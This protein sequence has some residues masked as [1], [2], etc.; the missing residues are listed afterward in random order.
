MSLMSKLIKNNETESESSL[1]SVVLSKAEA[2]VVLTALRQ[3][4]FKGEHARQVV[5]LLEKFEKVVI[6]SK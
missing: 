4:V 6:T 1:S 3:S 5:T 2:E